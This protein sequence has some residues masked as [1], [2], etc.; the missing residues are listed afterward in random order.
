MIVEKKVIGTTKVKFYDDY[1]DDNKEYVEK[2]LEVL[3]QRL[4]EKYQRGI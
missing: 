2:T 4:L 1:I 3:I